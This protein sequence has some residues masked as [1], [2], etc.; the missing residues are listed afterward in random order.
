MD[1]PANGVHSDGEQLSKLS[2]L[3]CTMD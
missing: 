3:E 1:L 2:A